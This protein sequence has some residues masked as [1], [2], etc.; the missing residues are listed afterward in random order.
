[1]VEKATATTNTHGRNGK[2]EKRLSRSGRTSRRKCISRL[3]PVLAYLYPTTRALGTQCFRKPVAASL[4][5]FSYIPPVHQTFFVRPPYFYVIKRKHFHYVSTRR[6]D[7]RLPP[8][9]NRAFVVRALLPRPR[10]GRFLVVPTIQLRVCTVYVFTRS[11]SEMFLFSRETDAI[12]VRFRFV[13]KTIERDFRW[14]GRRNPTSYNFFDDTVNIGPSVVRFSRIFIEN[15]SRPKSVHRDYYL[16]MHFVSCHCVPSVSLS[17]LYSLFFNLSI[18]VY[19]IYNFVQSRIVIS[20][21]LY[22]YSY[23][24]TRV[25]RYIIH[26]H[27]TLRWLTLALQRRG[28]VYCCSYHFCYDFILYIFIRC[29]IYIYDRLQ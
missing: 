8:N 1:M 5:I 3:V 25:T 15:A 24:T 6:E 28:N 22:W 2:S 17:L 19:S 9:T 14:N 18:A 16:Q 26:I 21:S 13:G 12:F 4:D 7:A 11:I 20:C 23:R 10:F 27:A 29:T